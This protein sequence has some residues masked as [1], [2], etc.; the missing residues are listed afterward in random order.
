MNCYSCRWQRNIGLYKPVGCS[1]ALL[2]RT[3]HKS[4]TKPPSARDCSFYE[5]GT[6]KVSL[7]NIYGVPN[8]K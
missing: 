1:N 4:R 3:Y 2:G 5:K 8:V 7:H 6:Y